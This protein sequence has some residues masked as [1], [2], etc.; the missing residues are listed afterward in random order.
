MRIVVIGAS[1]FVGEKVV[2][3]ALLRGHQVDAIY[4][5]NKI[6]ER[7]N[8]TQ[9]KMTIFDVSDFEKIIE[10]ADYVI[11]AYN[12][13]YYHVAQKERYLDGYEVIF[14]TV[15]KLNKKIVVVIG[16]TTLIQYDGETVRQGFFPKPWLK[17]L[18]GPDAVYEKYKNDSSLQVSFIS[19]A[20]ELIEGERTGKFG[21]GKDHLLYDSNLESRISVQ[22]LA[23]AILDEVEN[24]KHLGS[25]FTI[26][27]Q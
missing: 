4:R 27:Y 15:K 22:D 19:P 10:K 26:A 18:E 6:A 21:I 5:R 25:R 17:A 8:L 14:N 9:H 16:A 3:E 24:P 12:P 23:Y 1:G 7:D 20:A 11:S 2:N 13:G